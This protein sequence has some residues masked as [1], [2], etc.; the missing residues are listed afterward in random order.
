MVGD[1]F[2]PVLPRKVARA[3]SKIRAALHLRVHEHFENPKAKSGA[4]L[5]GRF[6]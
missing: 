5:D 2:H 4:A 3:L 6:Y 1:D